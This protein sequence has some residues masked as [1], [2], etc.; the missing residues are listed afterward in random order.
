MLS[1]NMIVTK[2]QYDMQWA[3]CPFCGGTKILDPIKVAHLGEECTREKHYYICPIMG[4]GS[5][6][7]RR[8][9]VHANCK[10]LDQV[11]L[12]HGAYY[13]GECRNASIA[14]YN[15]ETNRFTYMREKFGSI[16]VEAIGH[17]ENDDGF[18]I[19]KPYGLVN[20]PPFEI[21]FL[22]EGI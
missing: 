11:E 15:A 12:V 10:V 5:L 17:A 2:A 8:G 22:E 4:D 13:Y 7:T 21:P 6:I 14:R 19:F 16:F 1:Y 18:D 3:I 20:D 9:G